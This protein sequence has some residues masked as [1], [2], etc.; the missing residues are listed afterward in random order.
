MKATREKH[1]VDQQKEHE[2]KDWLEAEKVAQEKAWVEVEKAA[3]RA[4]V[5]MVSTSF[6]SSNHQ[7][8]FPN[9]MKLR[10]Y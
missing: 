10:W 2:E 5:V 6:F 3:V 7:L 1:W 8:I 4:S 9:R